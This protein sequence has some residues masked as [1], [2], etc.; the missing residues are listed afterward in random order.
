M[1][2]SRS[3]TSI[4]M[5]DLNGFQISQTIWYS[6]QEVIQISFLETF[7]IL[8]CEFT[9]WWFAQRAVKDDE[10]FWASTCSRLITSLYGELIVIGV[11]RMVVG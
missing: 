11:V 5:P 7:P 9:R 1:E 3:F 4:I 10:Q 8:R 6:H 2:P